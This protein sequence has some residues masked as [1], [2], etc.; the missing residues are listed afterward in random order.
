MSNEEIITYAYQAFNKRQIDQVLAFFDPEVDWPNGWEGGYVHGHEEVRN[1]WERQWAEINPTVEPT[2]FETSADGR[3][4][5]TV[6]QH[7]ED[8]TG[9][10][11]F[12]GSIYHIYT[13]E[14]GLIRKM[15]IS[16]SILSH[17]KS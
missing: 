16:D 12:S 14:N 6:H 17:P 11:L 13:F 5:V 10:V 1:Y 8:P 15:E 9:I 2:D 3:F 7:V 4:R